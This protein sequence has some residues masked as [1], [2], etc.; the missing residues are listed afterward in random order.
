MKTTSYNFDAINTV[1]TITKD[2]ARKAPEPVPDR[3]FSRHIFSSRRSRPHR[4]HFSFH[5]QA[6]ALLSFVLP[7]GSGPCR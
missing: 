6:S 2:F 1:L 7:A 3:P 5:V 4:L